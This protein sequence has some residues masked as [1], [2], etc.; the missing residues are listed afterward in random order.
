MKWFAYFFSLYLLTLSGFTCN[1][2]DDCCKETFRT[3]DSQGHQDEEDHKPVNP[4]IP[5]LACGVC[6][7]VFTP[8]TGIN[9]PRFFF[10][11]GKPVFVYGE[12]PCT[13][14]IAPLWQP[15]RTN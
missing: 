10:P 11:T 8:Q 12:A 2:E 1:A 3:E 5:F 7:G 6:H 14:S 13:V 9:I 4:C 15:P